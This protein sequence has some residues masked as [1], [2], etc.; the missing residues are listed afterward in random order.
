MPNNSADMYEL[1]RA[2]RGAIGV[3]V[4][5]PFESTGRIESTQVHNV[6][7]RMSLY[8]AQ[9]ADITRAVKLVTTR[10]KNAILPC[11]RFGKDLAAVRH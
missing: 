8:Y 4:S 1:T 7:G 11:G 5:A 10:A 3:Q 2:I 6:G 9:H